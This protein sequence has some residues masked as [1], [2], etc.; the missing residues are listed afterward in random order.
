MSTLSQVKTHVREINSPTELSDFR[1]EWE[2]LLVDT[3]RAS[4]FQTLDWLTI[5]WR[6]FGA[7][8]RLRT[9]LVYEAD[10]LLG[11][12]P[13]AVKR[14]RT[15]TGMVRVLSFPLDG[16]GTTYGPIGSEVGLILRAGLTH[17]H[18]TARDWD[19]LD[20]P[21]I[22]NEHLV[23][24]RDACTTWCHS[25]QALAASNCSYIRFPESWDEYWMTRSAKHRH[26]VR[27]AERKLAALG[28]VETIQRRSAVSGDP[29]WDLYD[30]CEHLA[31]CTW[32]GSS[33]TGNTLNH[34]RVRSFLRDVHASVAHMGCVSQHL[35][36]V[37]GEPVAFS[38][39]YVFRGTTLGLRMGYDPRFRQVAPGCVLLHRV[40]RD[41]FDHGDAWFDLG[42]GDANYK[43]L[44]RNHWE[45][46]H[47]VCQYAAASPR[48]QLLRWKRRWCQ[49]SL[50]TA[51]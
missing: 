11:I 26:N 20:L 51:D 39:N 42:E 27:R 19:V 33:S 22:P 29:H 8:Q 13:L 25:P 36:L 24:Y 4:W 21:G 3:P 14:E 12:L 34:P 18:Q 45:Q 50:R 40:I 15:R 37:N 32:Q 46:R 41:A 6:H 49:A 7:A 17:L 1:Q 10:R 2:R 5:Y 44:W 16:W 31:A 30:T 35:L 28:Q 9:L 48:A 23:H 38:Y 43:H 47:R